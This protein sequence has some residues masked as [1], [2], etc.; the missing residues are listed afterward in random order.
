MRHIGYLPDEP[1]ARRFSDYLL[2]LGMDLNIEQASNGWSLWIAHDDHLDR[3]RQE[4]AAFQASPDDP[5]YVA[6]RAQGAKLRAE[7]EKRQRRLQ[8]KHIDVR[9]SWAFGRQRT[10]PVTI[11]LLALS[12]FITLAMWAQ[13]S[14]DPDARRPLSVVQEWSIITVTPR[15]VAVLPEV[16]HG[17]I[18]RLVTPIFLHYSI[19]HL[20][21]NMFWL[22]DL[23]GAIENRKGTRTL[24]L[25][26]LAGSVLPN[27]MQY[28]W[29][30]PGYI[31]AFGGMSGVVYA[32]FGYVWMKGRYEP[33]EQLGV[34]PQTVFIMLVWLFVASS[35]VGNVA[36]AAHAGGLVVG[37][38]A[39]AGPHFLRRLRRKGL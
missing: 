27:L 11:A 19:M 5:R 18:W 30:D 10:Q 9:T 36:N 23:G 1:L 2:T 26:V 4:L 17:Q 38:I 21:F 37:I 35:I 25:L 16:M 15:Q 31:A 8:E 6:A 24:G 28:F 20:V 33:Q 13:E 22:W 14:R 3:A 34:T 12:V 7:T 32:L 39:G 29:T